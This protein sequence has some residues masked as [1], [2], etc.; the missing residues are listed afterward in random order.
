MQETGQYD[1]FERSTSSGFPQVILSIRVSN[2]DFDINTWL[3]WIRDVPS[4]ATKTKVDG[5]YGSL[6]TLIILRMPISLWSLL[7]DDT[8]Y[9]FI[10]FVTTENLATDFLASKDEMPEVPSSIDDYLRTLSMLGTMSTEEIDDT[11]HT[12][13]L[14]GEDAKWPIDE[15][16][17]RQEKLD[18]DHVSRIVEVT[19][20]PIFLTSSSI[21]LKDDKRKHDNSQLPDPVAPSA[22]SMSSSQ[23]PD[24]FLRLMRHQ[25]RTKVWQCV[26]L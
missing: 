3:E 11:E 17:P 18:M 13:C 23:Q 7:P 22:P 12:R 4:E 8:A 20:A 15:Q 9:S 6:S 16:H 24:G 1:N 5:V 10:G 14:G 25:G 19:A 2:T 21:N 26:S